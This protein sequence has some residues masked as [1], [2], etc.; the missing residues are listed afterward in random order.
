[1][2]STRRV[3]LIFL[4]VSILFSCKK[5]DDDSVLGLDVQP[6]NDLLGVTIS[7]SASIF[8]HT[9]KVD[10]VRTYNDQYKYLGSTIDPVFGR[11]DASIYTNYSISNNLTNV[12]FGSNPVLDSAEMLIRY[13]GQ[14]LGDTATTLNYEVYLLNEKLQNNTPYYTNKH[15]SRSTNPINTG[16]TKFRVIGTYLYLVLPLDHN[17]AQYILQTPANLTNN[18]AFQNANKGFYITTANTNTLSPV[19]KGAI[20]RFDLD[21]EFSGVNLYYHDGSSTSAKGKSFQFTFRNND[22]LRINN[23]KHNYAAGAI[24]NLY[25]QITG[26]GTADTIKGNTNVYLNCFGGTRTRVYLPY[27]KAFSDSQN[28]SISRAELIIKVDETNGYSANFAYPQNLALIACNANGVEE[29]VWDQL[30]TSDFVKYDGSYDATNKQYVFNIARQMQKIITDKITNYGFYLVNADPARAQVVRR[31]NR[32]ERVVIGG[33][34]S[35]T[36][37]PVF[38]VTYIKFPY[39]K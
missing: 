36:Y 37:K 33:K 24:T 4:C 17:M 8:M 1:M 7:D 19:N 31:D 28:V 9:Q 23:I 12:S 35:I 13:V 27:M 3:G 18:T 39:D 20:K 26:A 2:I 11:T 14:F 21:D 15:F 16:I 29:L 32:L 5:K 30:E 38:K 34:N 6:T 10:S 22:A 25:D